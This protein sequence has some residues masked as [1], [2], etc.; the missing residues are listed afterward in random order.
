MSDKL[1]V[2]VV[3]QTP[4]PYHGQAIMIERLLK[5]EFAH[6]ELRHVRMTFSNSIGEVGR[7]R[8]AKVLHLAS[9]ILQIV[10]QRIVHGTTVLYYPPAGPNRIP[11]YRD[12]AILCCTRWMFRRTVFHIHATGVSELYP[13]L[14]PFVRFL[15]R[16]ALFNADSVIRIAHGGPNDAVLLKP[17]FDYVIPNGIDDD[18]AH[19]RQ[20]ALAR[21]PEKEFAPLR[22]LF[23]G[24]LRESK[25]VLD[26]IEACGMLKDR[27][28]PFQL[29]I[30]GQ[31]QSPEFEAALQVRIKQLEI[32]P[33]IEFL[34]LL[35]GDAKW[36]AYAQ[37]D[38]LCFPTFYES[39]TFPTVLL[40]G[41]SFGLPVVAT[42]WRGIPEIVDD[43]VTGFLV[44]PRDINA[45][46][47]RLTELQVSSELQ[48]RLGAAAR[49]KFVEQ[50]TVERF[51]NRMESAFVE[52]ADRNKAA[53]SASSD[54]LRETLPW[55]NSRSDRAE[56]K[57]AAAAHQQSDAEEL[58]PI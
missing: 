1:K 9:V 29:A 44:E 24:F 6:V 34:G 42:R 22:I 19:F 49:K 47:D 20:S 26:L 12:L 17:R 51:W 30:M 18:G 5:G 56:T 7:F 31:F 35:T 8:F 32:G 15:F 40:E 53:S 48:W 11:L 16:R 3:G 36:Q 43:G 25:G 33:Q 58:T 50:F 39:E 28:A 37:A 2:L 38:V 13:K 10:W 55:K 54:Q 14:S 46:A 45:I 41:M 21:G 52:V 57:A 4:P 27:G 23:V